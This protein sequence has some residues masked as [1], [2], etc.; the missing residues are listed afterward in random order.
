MDRMPGWTS[1]TY[2]EPVAFTGS[3]VLL[4]GDTVS[5]TVTNISEDG[6][7]IAYEPDAILPIGAEV[8][9]KFDLVSFAGTVR[10]AFNGRAGLRFSNSAEIT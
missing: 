10:W 9:L 6:C 2:R 8:R 3:V 1:R 7:Q 5:V 4:C